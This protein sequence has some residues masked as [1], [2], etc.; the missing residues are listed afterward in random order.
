[1]ETQ[2]CDKS[3]TNTCTFLMLQV[4]KVR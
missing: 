4:R 1:M 3:L 2:T